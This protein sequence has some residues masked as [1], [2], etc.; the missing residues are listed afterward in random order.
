MILVSACLLGLCTRYDG[1]HNRHALLAAPAAAGRV[2][3]V[4]PEQLGG[5]PTPRPAAEIVG[6][7]G[8]DVLAGRAR[9]IDCQG[10]DRTAAFVRGAE[11]TLKLARA[12]PVAAAVFK[13]GSP[14]CGVGCIYDGS[15]RR[16]VRGGSGVAASLLAAAGFTLYTEEELAAEKLRC[17]LARP[18]RR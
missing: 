10:A 7:D 18:P 16:I 11:E 12:F 3:P 17:I 4:C 2:V 6:G 8:A 13:A 15:F 9:V 14:S 1:G 5:L